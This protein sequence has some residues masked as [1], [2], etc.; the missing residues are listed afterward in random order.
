MNVFEFLLSEGFKKKVWNF[1]NFSGVGGFGKVIFH[2]N[3]K[4]TWSKNAQNCLNMH[5]KATYF[6]F[7]MGV[8]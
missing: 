3:K 8:V 1:P 2:K 6:F 5:L 4:K 7:N